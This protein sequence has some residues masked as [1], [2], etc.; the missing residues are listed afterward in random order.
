MVRFFQKSVLS[1]LVFVV[2]GIPAWIFL[3]ARAL[4]EPEGFWQ[5][6]AVTGLGVWI[7]G[8]FQFFGIILFIA[9]LVSLW[10]HEGPVW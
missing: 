2:C 3:G 1:F 6:L 10:T 5:N 8:G 4:L 9:A 7:L